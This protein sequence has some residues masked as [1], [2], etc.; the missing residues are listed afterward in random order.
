MLNVQIEPSWKKLLAE[1]FEKPY[2]EELVERVRQAYSHERVY[3]AGRLIFNA[4]NLCPVDKVK[5]VILGQDPYHGYGQAHGL[6]FSVPEGVK[7]PPSLQNIYT[8]LADDLEID[9]PTSGDLSGWARQG[10]LLLNASL[11]VAEGR[12]MSHASYGWHIFTD[13]VIRKLS[14]EREHLVFI[15]WGSFAGSKA[16][17][18]DGSKHLV[19]RSAHPSPLSAYRGFFK[20]KPFS[21]TNYYL[22]AHNITPIRWGEV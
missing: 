3:P 13:R 21:K 7:L 14:E 11:T 12:P 20:S 8:E 5:V 18:I 19:L 15:L 17:L 4:F 2:F 16:S 22:V 1:E 10:V 9:P 6:S